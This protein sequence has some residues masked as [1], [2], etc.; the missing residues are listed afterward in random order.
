MPFSLTFPLPILPSR[1]Q[2]ILECPN[3][4][5]RPTDQ[6]TLTTH[7]TKAHNTHVPTVP[8]HHSSTR[9]ALFTPPSKTQISHTC[10]NHPNVSNQPA[11]QCP[12]HHTKYK[13]HTHVPTVAN[14][15]SNRPLFA[16][17]QKFHQCPKQPS[18]VPTVPNVPANQALILSPKTTRSNQSHLSQHLRLKATDRY[19]HRTRKIHIQCPDSSR[20]P[21][22]RSL[23][24]VPN[25]PAVSTIHICA[26]NQSTSI[27]QAAQPSQAQSPT[28]SNEFQWIFKRLAECSALQ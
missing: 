3:D 2:K 8:Y 21:I 20:L 24:H 22:N 18:D 5:T 16:T 12:Q 1:H 13:N 10:P 11:V 23:R 25:V 14:V 28:V 4:H 9:Q 15:P 26:H 7:Q 27:T 19:P 6:T 17:S